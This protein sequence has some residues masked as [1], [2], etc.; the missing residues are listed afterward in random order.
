[1]AFSLR[2]G[3]ISDIVKTRLWL[4]YYSDVGSQGESINVRNILIK[5]NLSEQNFDEHYY[6]AD[7][8][9]KKILSGEIS[10]DTAVVMFS[11]EP[12]A[13]TTLGRLRKFPKIKLKI[14]IL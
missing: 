4:S 9:R 12:N 6:F 10:F 13:K 1:V 11:D 8:I 7:S 3:E 5:V 14:L 2:P